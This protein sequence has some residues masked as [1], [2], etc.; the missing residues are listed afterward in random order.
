MTRRQPKRLLLFAGIVGAILAGACNDNSNMITNPQL[1]AT[2]TPVPGAPTATPTPPGAP[3]ATPAPA[4]ERIVDV[5]QNGGN[6]FADQ[7][8][9]GHQHAAAPPGGQDAHRRVRVERA[10]DE[11]PSQPRASSCQPS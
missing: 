5:G 10:Q 1:T 3:T 6:S 7:Q 11:R 2:R 4:A 9:G 8:S